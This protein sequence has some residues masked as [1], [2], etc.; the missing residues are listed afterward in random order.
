MTA[1]TKLGPTL[2]LLYLVSVISIS[3]RSCLIYKEGE[4]THKLF[5][6]SEMFVEKC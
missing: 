4:K 5:V 6:F 1:K 2:T 3:Q